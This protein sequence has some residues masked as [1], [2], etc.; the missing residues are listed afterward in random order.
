VFFV[1]VFLLLGCLTTKSVIASDKISSWQHINSLDIPLA[2]QY[3]T[4]NEQKLYIIGGA[5]INTFN[6]SKFFPINNSGSLG[7]L[8]TTTSQISKYQNTGITI[9]NRV[10]IFGGRKIDE[11]VT[12][13]VLIGSIYGNGDIDSWVPTSLLP[14]G[15]GVGLGAVVEYSGNIYYAGGGT[16]GWNNGIVDTIYKGIIDAATG[17]ITSWDLVGHLPEPRSGFDMFVIDNHLVIVGGKSGSTS[18]NTVKRAPISDNILASG[19]ESLESLPFGLERASSAIV[20]NYIVVAGGKTGGNFHDEVLT[21]E[22]LT[23]GLIGPWQVSEN[24]LPY[25]NCCSPLVANGNYMYLVGGKDETPTGYHSEVYMSEIIDSQPPELINL[26][27]V[28]LKQYEGGWE[29]EIY[30]HTTGNIK[31]YGCALTSAAMIL[32]YHGNTVTPKELNDWLRSQPDGYLRNGLINWLAI[33][34]YSTPKLEYRKIDPTNENILNELE[35]NRPAIIE[36]PGHFV[37]VR[38]QTDSSFAIN[39]PG[40][41]DRKTLDVYSEIN[42]LNTF[43]PSMTD[44]SYMMFVA[45]KDVKIQLASSSGEIINTQNTTENPIESLSDPS[46]KS[47]EIL[48]ILIHPKPVSGDYK[49]VV[50]KESPGFYDLDTYLYDTL[51]NVT[52]QNFKGYIFGQEEDIYP[53][54]YN[55]IQKTSSTFQIL[56]SDLENGYKNKLIRPRS[57]YNS[58]KKV[59]NRSYS[60]FLKGKTRISKT[61]LIAI[62]RQ[63][64]TTHP[65]FIN[66]EFSKVLRSS[67]DSLISSIE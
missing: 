18:L 33:S 49:L 7:N 24:R 38:G 55:L 63:I 17:Q 53:I 19:W 62:K 45:D 42:S 34:R 6:Y 28:D 46:Q 66:P 16:N 47:G 57:Y 10:Y 61:M 35:Q 1:L 29:D 50:S 25:K 21:S 65:F 12:N 9:D 56:I 39:D 30:D 64:L 3:S 23:N 59:V 58:I 15:V 52:K 20:K 54:S 41:L 40:Y 37:T 2:S 67:L 31:D 13:E 14:S 4:I 8:F 26:D 43:T 51:G 36:T 11:S 22:I 5:N 27:V 32:S 48:F 44:L 60:L